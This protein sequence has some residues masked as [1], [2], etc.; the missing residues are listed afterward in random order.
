MKMTLVL[1]KLYFEFRNPK[2]NKKVTRYLRELGYDLSEKQSKLRVDNDGEIS[3]S[4]KFN[5]KIGT[6]TIE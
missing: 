1:T 5:K 4:T 6:V 3:W 2:T